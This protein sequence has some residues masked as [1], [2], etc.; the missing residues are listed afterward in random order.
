MLIAQVL[1]VSPHLQGVCREHVQFIDHTKPDI[2]VNVSSEIP[3]DGRCKPMQGVV[4]YILVKL[5]Q[6]PRLYHCNVKQDLP[7]VNKF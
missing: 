4:C 7:V 2:R 3:H 6:V 1:Y 5:L